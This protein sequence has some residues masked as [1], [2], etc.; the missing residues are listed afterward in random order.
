MTAATLSKAI[1]DKLDALTGREGVMGC[2]LVNAEGY[3]LYSTLPTEVDSA[4]LASITSTLYSNNN[5]SIQRMDRG[6]LTQMT[7]LTD[8]GILHLYKVG[9]HLLVVFTDAAKKVDL[10]VLLQTVEEGC[11][12]LEQ[13]LGGS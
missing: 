4:R 10:G 1:Q 5:V 6:S 12:Q 8:V 3:S 2:M 11:T 7:L 13:L 9:T